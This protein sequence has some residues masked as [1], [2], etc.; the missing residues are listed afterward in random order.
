MTTS[1]S[2]SGVAL[3]ALAAAVI[4]TSMSTLSMAADGE[5][6]SAARGAIVASDAVARDAIDVF[7][8]IA[9]DQIE[10]KFI[11]LNANKANLIVAN[12]T[13]Q[14]L[15][16][17]LPEAFAGMPVLAQFGADDANQGVGGGG[18]GGPFNI[19]PEKTRK[20]EVACVC[21]EH[22]KPDPYAKVPYELK[23]LSAISDKPEVAALIARYSKG[24]I[25]TKAA[26]AAAWHL[27]NG[28]S[29][30]EL[31]AKELEHVRGPNE[32]YF[33]RQEIAAAMKLAD[34]AVAYAKQQAADATSFESYSPGAK[35]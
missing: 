34:G 27:Q 13:K 26:Q 33:T 15:T 28:M 12:K 19:A 10:V 32:P 21:L 29:W 24:D 8:A 3:A 31:A 20:V 4:C 17:K 2:R 22:G 14:P 30:K 23:P 7:D 5:K 11:A 35:K 25:S 9:N 6:A 1:W 16:I 18:G